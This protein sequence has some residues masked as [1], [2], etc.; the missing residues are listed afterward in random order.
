VHFAN[1]CNVKHMIG[2]DRC[3]AAFDVGKFIHD[4]CNGAT[5][6]NNRIQ[7]DAGRFVSTVALPKMKEAAN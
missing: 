5:P 6:H 4:E 7:A 2:A 3:G 1:V